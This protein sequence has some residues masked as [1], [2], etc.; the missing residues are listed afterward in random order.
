M[1][2]MSKSPAAVACRSRAS[3]TLLSWPSL[4]RRTAAAT[5]RSQSGAVRLPSCQRIS[6][7]TLSS[8]GPAAR[9]PGRQG[10]YRCEPG[11]AAAAADDHLRYHE[12]RA[13]GR[14]V[15]GEAAEGDRPAAGCGH[16]IVDLGTVEQL[17]EPL[18]PSGEPVLAS[19][20]G[21][22]GGL[23]PPGQAVTVPDPG[24]ARR[25]RE[26]C[27]QVA[28]IGDLDGLCGKPFR[29]PLTAVL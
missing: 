25:F 21:D 14:G 22:P 26:Q 11:P 10:P 9:V 3:T 5:A 15:E 7:G 13:V 6:A 20:E 4:M 8:A 12:H 16:L 2:R 28:G 29:R 24:H 1:T 23:P 17:A 27:H 18:L 19:G